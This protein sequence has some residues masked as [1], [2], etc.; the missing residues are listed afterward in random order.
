MAS[1][2]PRD[3]RPKAPYLSLALFLPVSP[4]FFSLSLPYL[5]SL[6]PP[7]SLSCARAS[8][9]P[10]VTL[11]LA[12][13]RCCHGGQRA[14]RWDGPHA[15]GCDWQSLG[16]WR[17][18]LRCQRECVQRCVQTSAVSTR[19][20][21]CQTHTNTERGER[22]Q[23]RAPQKARKKREQEESGP[24]CGTRLSPSFTFLFL[25]SPLSLSFRVILLSF[26]VSLPNLSIAYLNTLCFSAITF[27]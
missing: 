22:V 27:L 13:I 4:Y 2:H 3:F 26:H 25:L 21:V 20:S 17:Y 6:S 12:C 16:S 9:S 19:G 15:D 11:F 18:R 1:L 14:A 23:V 5:L 7:L 10:S 24:P 8:V